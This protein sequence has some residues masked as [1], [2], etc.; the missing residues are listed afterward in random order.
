[1]ELPETCCDKCGDKAEN[2]IVKEGVERTCIDGVDSVL[3]ELEEQD[4]ETK[5]NS[6]PG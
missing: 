1:M 2:F 5:E 3:F 6:T 4:I